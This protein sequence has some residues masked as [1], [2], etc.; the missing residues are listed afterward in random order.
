MTN[1]EFLDNIVHLVVA[2]WAYLAMRGD[3]SMAMSG[4]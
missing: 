2:V 3:K 1:L 4:G